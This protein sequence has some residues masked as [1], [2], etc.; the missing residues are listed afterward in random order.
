MNLEKVLTEN[1]LLLYFVG[2]VIFGYYFLKFL[3]MI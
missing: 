3:G 1:Q 2:L